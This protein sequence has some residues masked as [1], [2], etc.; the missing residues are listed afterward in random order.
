MRKQYRAAYRFAVR[1]MRTYSTCTCTGAARLSRL[2]GRSAARPEA[3]HAHQIATSYS[4]A[5]LKIYL[6]TETITL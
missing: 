2:A 6:R 1:G 3:S 5:N 4:L